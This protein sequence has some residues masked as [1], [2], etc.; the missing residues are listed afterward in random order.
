MKPFPGDSLP[1]DTYL[2]SVLSLYSPAD[3]AIRLAG[4]F[5][6]HTAMHMLQAQVASRRAIVAKGGLT[7]TDLYFVSREIQARVARIEQIVAEL[8]SRG[9]VVEWEP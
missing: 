9:E 7:I 8:R 2:P 3:G 4:R 6:L 5:I 1:S